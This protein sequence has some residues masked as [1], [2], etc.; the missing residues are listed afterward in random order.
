MNFLTRYEE[1]GQSFRP[2]GL[3]PKKSLRINTL[4]INPDVLKK[5]LE[6]NSVKLEKIPYTQ[7]GYFYEADFSLGSTP[8]YL[9]GY[10]YLQEA[11]SQIPAQELNPSEYDLVLDMA[12]SPGSKTTHLAQIMENKGIIMAVDNDRR[13]LESLKNNLERSSVT[14]TILLKKDSRFITDLNMKFDKILLD[15]PCSGNFCIEPDYFAKRTLND[16]HQKSKVQKELL[17]AA[18]KSLKK[19]GLLVY[20]TCSLEPEEDEMVIDWLL[21]EYSDIHLEK[22]DAD[23]GTAGNVQVFGRTLDK[24]LCLTRKLWPHI[25]GTEGFFIA[26]LRKE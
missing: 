5:R 11:A 26:K 8:E 9:Q 23:I 2:K 18:V 10:Y 6:K 12:A 7:N 17:V 19:G 25:T 16:L 3:E 24:S 21:K 14:N 13:R 1:L 4:K 22:I 15:A 20:S